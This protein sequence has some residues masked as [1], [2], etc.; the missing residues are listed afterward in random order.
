MISLS[1]LKAKNFLVTTAIKYYKVLHIEK[2]KPKKKIRTQSPIQVP[3]RKRRLSF[4]L[5]ENNQ[6]QKNKF[7]L[8]PL[9][10]H[11]KPNNSRIVNKLSQK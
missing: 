11:Q 5:K 6:T 1:Q 8:M 3:N 7:P 10:L 4:C 9:H 2:P